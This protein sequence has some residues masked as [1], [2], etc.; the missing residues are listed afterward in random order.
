[1][2]GKRYS[3][4]NHSDKKFVNVEQSYSYLNNSDISLMLDKRFY[5]LNHSDISLML[6]KR[7]SNLNHSDISLMLDNRFSCLNHSDIFLLML[8]KRYSYRDELEHQV[9]VDKILSMDVQ[10]QN[11][12]FETSRNT[13]PEN[14]I[15]QFV[16]IS[17]PNIMV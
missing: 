9:P 13:F 7:Y 1:M 2:L 11:S 5:Y 10:T 8:D 17:K 4:L 16:H 12:P 15:N 14:V 3:Y 6:D